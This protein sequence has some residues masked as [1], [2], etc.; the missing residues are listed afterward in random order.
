MDGQPSLSA[1]RGGRDTGRLE[2]CSESPKTARAMS[3]YSGFEHCRHPPIT[4][5][6]RVPRWTWKRSSPPHN[7]QGIPALA[8]AAVTPK[9]SCHSS[10]V[11]SRTAQLLCFELRRRPS[12]RHRRPPIV[13]RPRI[14][15]DP[16]RVRTV[17]QPDV[18]FTRAAVES[19]TP[20]RRRRPRPKPH[21][22]DVRRP[23]VRA[24]SPHVIMIVWHSGGDTMVL[25]P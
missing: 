13:I 8:L 7:G 22:M 5:C 3:G 20:S 9:A 6:P 18:P 17:A 16:A 11:L 1:A 25:Y 15:V 24:E 21:R 4:A 19:L 14:T 23:V 10:S 2:S 12:I